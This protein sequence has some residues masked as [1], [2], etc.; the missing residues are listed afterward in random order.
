M[1]RKT[2]ASTPEHLSASTAEFWRVVVE[3]YRI[4]EA[5]ALRLL[6][7]CCEALD[8]GTRA[9]LVLA[10]E[11]LTIVDRYGVTKPHPCAA[12][13][14]NAT[15]TVARLLRE[16]RIVDPIPEARPARIA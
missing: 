8:M 7:L 2:P 4:D 3:T 10:E 16:L 13:E 15:I 14:R 9:R 11:G 1:V 6:E 12:I 5:P